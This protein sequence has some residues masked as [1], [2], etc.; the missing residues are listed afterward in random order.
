MA[1]NGSQQEINPIIQMIVT[2]INI[3]IFIGII[4][5]AFSIG[6]IIAQTVAFILPG[7]KTLPRNWKGLFA[8]GPI[9]ICFL[10]SVTDPQVAIVMTPIGLLGLWYWGWYWSRNVVYETVNVITDPDK[11]VTEMFDDPM[12]IKVLH[13][14]GIYTKKDGVMAL[15]YNQ[16]NDTDPVVENEAKFSSPMVKDTKVAKTL[17]DMF[18][19]K[20]VKI[21]NDQ[22]IYTVEQGIA[23]FCPQPRTT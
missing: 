7:F 6:Y 10:A 5:F 11:P 4:L 20:L 3:L 22:G 19:D 2:I 8:G 15:H 18:D 21:L 13:D 17:N 14:Q 9:G 12:V 16:F 1:N 23:A